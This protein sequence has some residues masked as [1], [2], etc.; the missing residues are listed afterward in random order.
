MPIC[1][2]AATMQRIKSLWAADEKP[3]LDELKV[4]AAYLRDI[5]RAMSSI[6]AKTDQMPTANDFPP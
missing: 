2:I 3:S 5:E 6:V 1:R 4:M